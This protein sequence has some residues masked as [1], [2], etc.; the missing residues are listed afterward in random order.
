MPVT[1]DE[2]LEYIPKELHEEYRKKLQELSQEELEHLKSTNGHAKALLD[3]IEWVEEN[4]YGPTI[5]HADEFE[6]T[7][8]DIVEV[9]FDKAMTFLHMLIKGMNTVQS[10]EKKRIIAR[11]IA[12]INM[13][14]GVAIVASQNIMPA[15]KTND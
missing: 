14:A 1:M 4:I 5:L 10:P 11:H 2:L 9:I 3:E 7:F 13:Q 6:D 15:T 12:F 8:E